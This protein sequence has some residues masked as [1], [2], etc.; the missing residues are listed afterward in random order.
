MEVIDPDKDDSQEVEMQAPSFENNRPTSNS[1]RKRIR[2]DEMVD[3]RSA[4]KG[5][6]ETQEKENRVDSLEEN[7][8]SQKLDLTVIGFSNESCKSGSWEGGKRHNVNKMQQKSDDMFDTSPM[9]STLASQQTKDSTFQSTK[10][11]NAEDEE[12]IFGFGDQKRS[13]ACTKDMRQERSVASLGPASRKRNANEEEED[14]IFGFSPVKKAVPTSRPTQRSQLNGS[15]NTALVHSPLKTSSLIS[16]KVTPG[17]REVT[18]DTSVIFQGFIGKGDISLKP[19]VEKE[20][21]DE[22]SQLSKSLCKVTLNI[23]LLH[24]H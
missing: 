18:M 19:K 6:G 21:G 14:D 4:K 20:E 5:R 15:S 11:S 12:D 23:F 2:E 3:T 10:R 16:E 17:K 1:S 9:K 22:Y 8:E 13:G 7:S 24:L